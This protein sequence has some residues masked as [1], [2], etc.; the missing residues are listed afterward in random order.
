[1]NAPAGA[2][3]VVIFAAANAT[4]RVAD[5][6][7]HHRPEEQPSEQRAEHG[8]HRADRGSMHE[9]GESER[10]HVPPDPPGHV[11]GDMST[12]RMIELMQMDDDAPFGRVLL[13]Q[14]EWRRSS[15]ADVM[16]WELD[17]WYGDDYDKLWLETEG[18]K[19]GGDTKGRVEI[20][21]D[22]IVSPWWSVQ[23]GL[24]RDIG[25]GPS[26]TW[27]DLGV[28]GT[29]PYG[30]EID[31]AVYIGA[32]GRV[33]ARFSSEY[34]VLIAQRLVLQPELEVRAYSKDD[35]ENGIGS[36][37]ADIELALRLRY[38]IRREIAPYLGVYWKR[39]F[40]RTADL[41]RARGEEQG[42]TSFV[43]GVRAWF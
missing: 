4:A 22:R 16:S 2:A 27:L 1:M 32:Q 8:H 38:E 14:L 11:M 7:S 5:D 10:A 25:S 6:H 12:H 35:P 9:P 36:G 26:R 33:A 43:A 30:V 41:A 40:G 29:A 15:D 20:M 28:Q 37:L 19:L 23:T 31:A 13:D 18:E 34:D 17:A 21:W 24:R 3:V 42:G 39:S